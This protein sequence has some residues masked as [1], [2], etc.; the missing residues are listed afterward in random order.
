MEELSRESG[1]A[2]T[3]H[4]PMSREAHTLSPLR[5]PNPSRAT[6]SLPREP[7]SSG[8]LGVTEGVDLLSGRADALPSQITRASLDGE[9]THVHG[10]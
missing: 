7:V 4:N 2:T 9:L 1:E 5:N 8:E 3:P 6:S 10:P